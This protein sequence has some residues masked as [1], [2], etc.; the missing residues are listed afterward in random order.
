MPRIYTIINENS[1][2]GSTPFDL[3][4]LMPDAEKPIELLGLTIECHDR[5]GVANEDWVNLYFYRYIGG[6]A[7]GGTTITPVPLSP[8][9]SAAATVT[10]L[11]TTNSGGTIEVIEFPAFNLRKGFK[12]FYPEGMGF[13]AKNGEFINLAAFKNALAASSFVSTVWFR[14]YP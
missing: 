10:K 6:T 3:G 9:D 12:V 1:T 14:E 2:S 5:I 13:F 8:N 4:V 7:T 11:D